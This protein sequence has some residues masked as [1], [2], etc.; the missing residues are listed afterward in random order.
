M[1]IIKITVFWTSL[2][3]MV[4]WNKLPENHKIMYPSVTPSMQTQYRE[5]TF[6]A[7]LQKVLHQVSCSLQSAPRLLKGFDYIWGNFRYFRVSLWHAKVNVKNKTSG[8]QGWENMLKFVECSYWSI[9]T[10]TLIFLQQGTAQLWISMWLIQL[11]KIHLWMSDIP[12]WH[13]R[14]RVSVQVFPGLVEK[15]HLTE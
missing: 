15:T 10:L 5:I 11:L 4:I 9:C 14:I 3:L 1:H 13:H 2:S 6:V 7:L 8:L 12:Q